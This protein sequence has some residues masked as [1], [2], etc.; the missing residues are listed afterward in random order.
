MRSK[1]PTHCLILLARCLS[2]YACFC[3]ALHHPPHSP[4]HSNQHV[5][6]MLSDFSPRASCS[7]CLNHLK[8]MANLRVGRAVTADEV[9]EL[10]ASA[11][12]IVSMA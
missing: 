1:I 3:C 4:P 6:H 12:R 10:L 9:A 5:P 2:S 11:P 7:T 8:L